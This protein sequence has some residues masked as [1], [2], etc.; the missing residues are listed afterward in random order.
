LHPLLKEKELPMDF[1]LNEE[2][3]MIQSLAEDFVEGQLKPL[4]REILGK[5]ADL[6][7]AL[8]YLPA[9][10]EAELIKQVKGLGLWGIGVPEEMGGAGLNT[11]SVCLVEEELANTIIPFK[12]GDVTPVLFDCNQE[13]REKYFVPALNYE[14]FPYLALMETNDKNLAGMKMKAEKTGGNYILDGGK[15]SLSRQGNDYFAVVFARAIT[16]FPVSW[17]TKGRPDSVSAAKVN[18]TVGVHG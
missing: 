15:F 6:S 4:E 18:I 12:F 3:K 13:Q 9:E 17:S 14:K 2:Q 1:E 7:D 8:A 5:A 10:K 11:L 16:G